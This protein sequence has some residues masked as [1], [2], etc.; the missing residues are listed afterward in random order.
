MLFH[1]KWILTMGIL[2]L[3]TPGIASAGP[4]SLPTKAQSTQNVQKS[5][6]AQQNQKVAEAI[7][8]SLRKA[9]LNG[10]DIDI[11]FS[12]GTAT[13]K[14]MIA[15]PEQWNTATQIVR[16]IPGVNR[17][18]NQMGLINGNS[19]FVRPVSHEQKQTS[20]VTNS[21]FQTQGNQV[22]SPIMTV[23]HSR[24]KQPRSL[25]KKT[26][27]KPAPRQMAQRKAT[28]Q[29]RPATPQRKAVS[30]Q[31]MAQRIASALKKTSIN[32]YDIEI[33]YLNGEVQLGGI[34]STP[35]QKLEAQNA[36]SRIAGIRTVKNK[37]I[38]APPVVKAP[39]RPVTYNQPVAAPDGKMAQP[40]PPAGAKPMLPPHPAQMGHGGPM[41]G[42][43]P[44]MA[45]PNAMPGGY[46]QPQS[47]AIYNQ[48]NLPKSAWPSYAA[49]PNYA[50]VN[51]PKQY[52]ANAFPYIGP[53]Y[54]YPQV[55]MGWRK[56]ALEWDDGSWQLSFN[57][58][59]DRWWWFV[60]P[61]NW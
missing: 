49:Y 32:G 24:A 26:A 15:N 17:V 51:Y 46:G 28:P 37:L 2:A 38:V 1:R 22:A 21:A 19:N 18:E 6:T 12:K 56:A 58:K 16:S 4:F 40:M 34:V 20:T 60:N 45:N 36:V 35:T 31:E 33:R 9:Q 54:P 7:A 50:A 29:Q 23:A 10:Y 13:L 44:M 42:M 3:T 39:V 30:N 57:S 48:S 53:F 8:A 52:S 61:S 25:T 27:A 41:P 55:P 14:G 43:S 59:T 47:G 11:Q 5:T